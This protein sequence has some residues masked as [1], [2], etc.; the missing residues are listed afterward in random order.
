MGDN[1]QNITPES[2][3]LQEAR[4]QEGKAR[5]FGGKLS[6]WGQRVSDLA[7]QAMRMSNS[8]DEAVTG[9]EK[10]QT[11]LA[12]LVNVQIMNDHY[13]LVSNGFHSAADFDRFGT[14]LGDD[15]YWNYLQ[16]NE[17][18]YKKVANKFADG[19]VEEARK[20]GLKGAEAQDYIHRRIEETAQASG[21]PDKVL[22]RLMDAFDK[23]HGYEKLGQLGLEQDS[24]EKSDSVDKMI[25]AT[26]NMAGQEKFDN[27]AR[28]NIDVSNDEKKNKGTDFTEEELERRNDRRTTALDIEKEV[29]A[30]AKSRGIKTERDKF[31]EDKSDLAALLANNPKGQTA[32]ANLKKSQEEVEGQTS[33]RPA[34]VQLANNSQGKGNELG[35]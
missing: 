21:N 30:T 9:K 4:E 19:L 20:L 14:M 10:R 2:I 3:K 6:E 29:Y 35:A 33:S 7:S 23:G 5:L 27:L 18:E 1:P 34:D 28:K 32:Q 26:S 31:H 13:N 12:Q 15:N 22:P 16:N 25:T 24:P 8:P 11:Q 17:E